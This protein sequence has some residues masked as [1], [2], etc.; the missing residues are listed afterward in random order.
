[1]GRRGYLLF[2]FRRTHGF[3]EQDFP[4]CLPAP[5][6]SPL[7]VVPAQSEKLHP[8]GCQPF[9]LRIRRACLYFFD[10]GVHCVKL[11]AGYADCEIPIRDDETHIINP[12]C[13]YQYRHSVCF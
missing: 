5:D 12:V 4:V 1:M 2:N 6:D 11:Y 10:A 8:V 7:L 3:F 13:F 9:F